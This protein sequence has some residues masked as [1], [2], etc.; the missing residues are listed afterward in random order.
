MP[1]DNFKVNFKV[2]PLLEHSMKIGELAKASGFGKS[3]K[4]KSSRG[5]A[6]AAH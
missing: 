5:H 2:K 6:K 1:N 4:G 3:R